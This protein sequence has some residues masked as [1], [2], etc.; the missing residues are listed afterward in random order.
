LRPRP[1]KGQISAKKPSLDEWQALYEAATAFRN[2]RCWEWMYDDDLFGVMD[3]ETGEIAYC[4]IM[5]RLGK[6]YALGAYLGSEG[7]QSLLAIMESPYKL[8]PDLFFTQKCI[9]APSATKYACNVW[10]STVSSAAKMA[11]FKL[12]FPFMP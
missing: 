9:M 3:P 11:M 7:L 10:R 4:C 2:A 6:Q 5:G 1:E 12:F 8:S